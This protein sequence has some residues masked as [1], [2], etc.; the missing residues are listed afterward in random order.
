MKKRKLLLVESD[1]AKAGQMRSMLQGL[2]F[3]VE[4]C[5]DVSEIPACLH[6]ARPEF[7]FA[8]LPLPEA[9]G[10]AQT[11]RSDPELNNIRIILQSQNDYSKAEAASVPEGWADVFIF[12]DT[13]HQELARL[14]RR[15]PARN[16]KMRVAGRNPQDLERLLEA[17]S[18]A[19]RQAEI[20]LA[21]SEARFTNLFESMF[22]GFATCRM[23]YEQGQPVDFIYLN[24]NSTFEKLTGLK[25]VIGK[26][27]SEIIPGLRQSNPEIFEVYGRVVDTGEPERFETHL[28][29]LNLSLSLS[30]YRSGPEQFIV[31]F[32]NITQ[33]KQAEIALRKSEAEMRALLDAMTEI[34]ALHEVIYDAAGKA[35]DYRILDCNTAFL[36][37]I[38][39]TQ[40]QATGALATELFGTGEAPYLEIYAR[41]AESGSPLR[42]ETEYSPLAR[43]FSISVY[44]P[45][46]GLFGTSAT[47]ITAQVKAQEQLRSSE[48]D[49]KQSQRVAQVGS[50]KWNIRT[51]ELT[52]SDE[53]YRLFGINKDEFSGDVSEV[54]S[55]AV[56]PDDRQKVE[57]A[58]LAV[59]TRKA[60]QAL[61]YRVIWADGSIHTIW[62]EPGQMEL[63]ETGQ[64]VLLTGIAQDITARKQ[65][66]DELRRQKE[67]LQIILDASPSAIMFKDTSN[68]LVRVNKAAAAMAGISSEEME[69]KPVEQIF[70]E[71]ATRFYEDDL[72]VIRSGKPRLG[73]IE[74]VKMPKG[75][76]WSL[77]D[78]MPWM[79]EAGNVAGVIVFRTDI[80]ER[81]LAEDT[82]RESEHN[83][84]RSQ[85]IAHIGHWTL[86]V[87]TGA[88]VFSEE[89]YRIMGLDPAETLGD[90]RQVLERTVHPDDLTRVLEANLRIAQVSRLKGLEYRVVRPDGEI[91][92]V[93]ALP[94]DDLTDAVGNI[95]QIS[96]IV[97]DITERK[98]AQEALRESEYILSEAQKIAR[99]GS[100]TLD[101][102]SISLKSSPVLDE[103]IGIENS[104]PKN[105]SEWLN[106]VAP[107]YRQELEAYTLQVIGGGKRFE[108][109]FKIIRAS[110]GEQRWVSVLGEIQ[111]GPSGKPIR[112]IGTVQDISASKQASDLLRESEEKFRLAFN[113]ASTGM[114]LVSTAGAFMQVNA[115]LCDIVGYSREELEGKAVLDLTLPEDTGISRSLLQAM[116]GGHLDEITF[117]KRYVHKLGHVV[118]VQLASALVRNATGS[119]RYFITQ[120]QDITQ[121]KLAEVELLRY[122]DH[123]EELVK[124]R[125]AELVAAKEQAE[126]ANRA[127]S[128]FLANMSH[129][130]RT[131]LNGVLGMAQLALRTNLTQQQREFLAN[132]QVSGETLLA[133]INDI[134]DFSKVE[135]G[136]LDLEKANFNLEDVLQDV[137]NLVVHK[138]QEKGLELVL[139]VEAD[140]PL[141]LQGDGLRLGQVL[142]NLVG[143]AVKFTQAGEIVVKIKLLSDTPEG[144]VLQFSVRDTGI[145]MSPEQ[146]AQIFEPF[147]QADS[148]I[149]RRYGGTG[150]GLAICR[151]L[152]QLMDGELRVESG[153]GRGSTF[154]FSAKFERQG[155]AQVGQYS[156]PELKG[157]GV[158][159]VEDNAA[160][161][162]HLR[163]VLE[164]F[165]LRVVCVD[166]GAAGLALLEKLEQ[167][168]AVNLAL[169][170]KSLSGGMDGPEFSRRLRHLPGLKGLPVILMINA[171]ELLYQA[172]QPE[173]D[174]YITKPVSRSQLF[175]AVLQAFGLGAG[176]PERPSRRKIPSGPLTQLH[177][178]RVL[179]VEDNEINRIVATELLRGLGMIVS[180]AASGEEA[181]RLLA[182]SEYEAVLMD[183]QMPGMDGY[184]TTAHIRSDPRFSFEKLPVIAITAHALTGDREK[185][186]QAGLNDHITKP[187]DESQL[188]SVLVQWVKPRQ[189]PEPAAP[190]PV[191]LAK[192]GRLSG[193]TSGSLLD[194]PGI[195]SALGLQRLGGNQALFL[196]LLRLFR[197]NYAGNVDEIRAALAQGD[198]ESARR[199]AHTLKGVSGQISAGELSEAARVL[200]ANIAESD[201]Q[202]MEANLAQ[203]ERQL[204]FILD[205][206]AS[207]D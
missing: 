105:A 54:V 160:T 149:S 35:V 189:S 37:L 115:R 104:R 50:W 8:G 72:L 63:D 114:C 171:D 76:R 142:T 153:L 133:T 181:L 191:P 22:E 145:G 102:G 131:P 52:W 19:R 196:R 150:L 29:S 190:S 167:G 111:S 75:T 202:R 96:G 157:L 42:F 44:S 68:M 174:G 132:I 39:V 119:P 91:R 64:L 95:T 143:N 184:Q 185:S 192:P 203:L 101:F 106:I 45:E 6:E 122:R 17:S 175:N 5:A 187:I 13:P 205:S 26:R 173:L 23:I 87:Q 84:R 179:L 162:E 141:L 124:E 158:L 7:I 58:N 66:E 154:S 69:G 86:D 151:R 194:L 107:E 16:R 113:S 3:A 186:L 71:Q 147:N 4:I 20:A 188:A 40:E 200:E 47:D 90:M 14:T 183:I 48:A 65:A 25:D 176:Q 1:P 138:T 2:G 163:S 73:I 206:L 204:R 93:W 60:T 116:A 103:I 67:Q 82:L 134:L 135:A 28:P 97:Q 207:L 81:K 59:I 136:K 170:D 99:I 139:H 198:L 92:Q 125:T 83:L 100:F 126:E 166:S 85:Q 10:L 98:L 80:T 56:H 12:R 11:L 15:L 156:L 94:G 70:P 38:G 62:A 108:K 109:E 34:V 197:A 31:V 130:I 123:L 46:K 168:Q 117:E 148:S 137:A 172:A 195:D 79:D 41:V 9:G 77:T 53:M 161:R 74:P 24:V 61:E 140:V 129:E 128:V 88:Y 36:Q 152:V 164:S 182:Q 33:S 43:N 199:L 165:D 110:N 55:R 21:E 177:G 146:Q 155:Q 27:V 32:E 89:L 159:V 193:A 201:P 144:V 57:Q 127:K 121:R 120:V 118:D 78:K 49:L 180:N 178:G 169:V 18:S 30:V 112:M 51:N